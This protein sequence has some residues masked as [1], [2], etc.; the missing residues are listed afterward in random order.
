MS[1]LALA[2]HLVRALVDDAD[3]ARV[4]VDEQGEGLMI[5]IE[6]SDADRGSLIGRGGRTI[7]ALETILAVADREGRPVA[8]DL[9]D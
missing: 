8:I 3:A 9:V 7:R 5:R 2:E 4:S 1:V 6:V